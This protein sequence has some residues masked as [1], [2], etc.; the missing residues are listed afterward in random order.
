MG[1]VAPLEIVD[2]KVILRDEVGSVLTVT[3]CPHHSTI[4]VGLDL[5]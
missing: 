3:L 2:N 5:D 4:S 1:K